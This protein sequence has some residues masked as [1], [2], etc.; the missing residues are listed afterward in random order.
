MLVAMAW[1]EERS[2]LVKCSGGAGGRAMITA[3]S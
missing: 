3:Y 1:S 2:F